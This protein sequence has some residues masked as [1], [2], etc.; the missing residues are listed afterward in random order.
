MLYE[1]ITGFSLVGNDRRD[2]NSRIDKIFNFAEELGLAEIIDTEMEI[3][4]L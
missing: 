4:N 3:I 2:I 1:V